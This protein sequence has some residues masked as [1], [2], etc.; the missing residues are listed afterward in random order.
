MPSK[1]EILPLT[2]APASASAPSAAQP[3]GPSRSAVGM[4]VPSR[5]SKRGV[6][7][8]AANAEA[9]NAQERRI[10]LVAAQRRHTAFQL[11]YALFGLGLMVVQLEYVWFANTQD[12]QQPC[13]VDPVTQCPR[14][15]EHLREAVP[16]AGGRMILHALRVLISFSTAIL[17]YYIYAF[18]AAECEV[19]KIKNILPPRA[20]LLSSTL[21]GRLLLELLLFAVHPIPGLESV[22]PQWPSL[23]VASSLFMFARVP[24]LGRV[25]K[26][27]NSFNTSNGWFIGALTNVDFTTTYFL[28]STLKNHPTLCVLVVFGL[29]LAFTGYALF[30]V[31]RFLC[32]FRADA[33]CSPMAFDDALWALVM[34]VLTVGYG[35]V[36]PFTGVGRFLAF[37]A[38]LC[39][40]LCTAV[41]IA[42][43]SN[44]LG[45]T[46]SEH[47]VN[48][49]LKKDENRRLI[50]EH[51][52]RAIQASIHLRAMQRRQQSQTQSQ[53]Q[54]QGAAGKGRANKRTDW[55]VQR[56][57]TKLFAVLRAYRQV[58][59]FVNSQ[60]VSDPMDKQ[61]T[62]LEMMEVNVE[63]IRTK[64]E[65]LSQ[66]FHTQIEKSRSRHR[67]VGSVPPSVLAAKI[68]AAAVAEP[69]TGSGPSPAA[70]S[71]GSIS[72]SS[73]PTSS[74][75]AVVPGSAAAKTPPLS[76]SS[77]RPTS[78]DTSSLVVPLTSVPRKPSVP[79]QTS[80]HEFDDDDDDD[81]LHPRRPPDASRSSPPV[82]TPAAGPSMVGP[83]VGL[84]EIPEWALLMESTLQTILMQVARVSSD[85]EA[86]QTHVQTQLNGLH[87]R[88]HDL[89]RKLTVQDAFREIARASLVRTKSM[90][91]GSTAD[92]SSSADSNEQ[93]GGA[94]GGSAGAQAA[95]GSGPPV[96]R[97]GGGGSFV[98]SA[99]SRTSNPR[100]S[101]VNRTPSIKNFV[102]TKELEEFHSGNLDDK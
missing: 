60:D 95:S 65:D 101:F 69:A 17:L 94:D 74:P 18:Y 10:R 49:F 2:P 22:D 77:S 84:H 41:T 88:L 39:G 51:A 87:A 29:L 9:T 36:V 90:R 75:S 96:L 78:P 68:D 27:R 92:P 46:R 8:D 64:I 81:T 14:C 48:A 83:S 43:M 98:L 52:A 54:T 99:L 100:P 79:G 42:V 44:Y 72:T 61:M 70:A 30:V 97:H 59:R 35:D 19:M 32:A 24:L 85:V 6:R 33:C 38:G 12:L 67:L 47:K 25:I 7:N 4:P 73:A 16:V 93:P 13:P 91:R 3:S 31:E 62:M 63:Y 11:F 76:A 23:V 40:T 15:R 55:A 53:S 57:E 86:L 20:T 58:K 89:E 82:V 80:H 45:L 102:T 56:A 1:N 37:V 26:F 50:N 21:R 34:T 66:L 71:S 28:K 5:G